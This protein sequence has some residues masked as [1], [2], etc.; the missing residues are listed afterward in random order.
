MSSDVALVLRCQ[1]S[2][3]DFT[4]LLVSLVFASLSWLTYSHV[5]YAPFL[6][7]NMA[8][9]NAS[10]ALAMSSVVIIIVDIIFVVVVVVFVAVVVV[11]LVVARRPRND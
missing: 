7:H 10:I 2:S 8:Q 6:G 4:M 1:L 3:V 11:V 9:A 5:G